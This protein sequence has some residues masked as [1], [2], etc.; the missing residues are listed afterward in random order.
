MPSVLKEII[1]AFLQAM[2]IQKGIASASLLAGEQSLFRIHSAT[3]RHEQDAK[4]LRMA[5]RDMDI[6][7]GMLAFQGRYFFEF[8]RRLSR[9]RW[10]EAESR[11]LVVL[12]ISGVFLYSETL[13][14]GMKIKKF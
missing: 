3:A 2:R 12:S 14:D 4:R 7:P 11:C 6:C 9:P 5:S 10:S 8:T 13:W 1:C